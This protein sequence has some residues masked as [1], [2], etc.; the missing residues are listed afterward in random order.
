ADQARLDA[1]RADRASAA[2]A[3][4][5]SNAGQWDA[6]RSLHVAESEVEAAMGAA[7]GEGSLGTLVDIGT[8]TGR[9]LEL[10]GPRSA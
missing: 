9:M 8:G 6:I 3:W 10:F 5:E 7:L 2:E 4:F 1:V